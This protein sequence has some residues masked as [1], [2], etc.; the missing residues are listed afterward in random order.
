MAVLGKI[1]EKSMLLIVVIALGLFAFVIDPNTIIGFFDG[2]R[3][4][5]YIGKVNDETIDRIAFSSQ[6][7]QYKSARPGATQNAALT[8][9]WDQQVSAM[10][11]EEQYEKL[12]ITVEKDQLWDIFKQIN[13]NNP[14]YQNDQGVFD[15]NILRDE[16]NA[17]LEQNPS[18]LANIEE[19]YAGFP[20]QQVY[21]NLIRAGIGA[22]EKDGEQTYRRENDK[23]DLKFVQVPYTSIADTTIT[24]SN[25]EIAAYIQK[26]KAEYEV[27]ATTDI[28]LVLFEEKPSA[29][30][31]AAV[32]EEILKLL[33]DRKVFNKNSGQEELVKGF[34]NTDDV[35]LFLAENSEIAFDSVYKLKTQ[36]YNGISDTL[37]NM[38]PGQITEVYK[39][40]SHYHVSKV[41]GFKD[42]ETRSASHVLVAYKGSER[43]PIGL[44]RTKEEAEALAKEYLAELRKS[45]TDFAAFAK[46][47]SDDPSA[48]QNGGDMS[49]FGK[50]SNF[51]QEFKDFTFDNAVGS[52]DIVETS[53]GYHIIKVTDVKTDKKVQLATLAL[54]ISPS[55]ETLDKLYRDA[56]NFEVDAEK[57]GFMETAEKNSLAVLPAKKLGELTD[58]VSVIPGNQR[59]LVKW[60]FNEETKIGDI[61][62]FDYDNGHVVATLA[63][64]RPAGLASPDD[65]SVTVLPKIRKEKKAEMIKS[66]N[67]ATDLASFA[68]NNNV[69]VATATAVTMSSPNL[70]GAGNEPKVVG[71]AFGMK[72]GEVSGLIEGN[73]G[74]YMVEVVKVTPAADQESYKK[75]ADQTTL[76]NTQAVGTKILE[77]LK[78]KAEIEDNRAVLY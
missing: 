21:F 58:R 8:Q 63:K 39:Q 41:L 27:E 9:V 10:L 25:E 65:V 28:N 17:S 57:N 69:N 74:V 18:F 14:A 20:K 23:V 13:Q 49:F 59:Q 37:F 47:K 3:N 2:S 33:E 51:A 52:I 54:K 5:D 29:E 38:E 50:E 67:N 35:A 73:R 36:V 34:K 7:E 72:S 77:A 75:F 66:K 43:A 78:K 15:E 4:K 55:K 42:Y 16:L 60:S 68:Q 70:P 64:R 12:G 44:E 19:Q 31:E 71:A 46:E 1:R 22:T 24:V 53:F 48:K 11:L 26:N 30:D 45:S 6:I 32:K 40:N 56:Q 62:R 76:Q 61:K